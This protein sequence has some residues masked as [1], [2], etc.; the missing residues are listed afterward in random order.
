MPGTVAIPGPDS[1]WLLA[2]G[3]EVSARGDDLRPL[4]GRRGDVT[5]GIPASRLSVF[6]VLLPPTDPSLHDRMIFAQVEKRGLAGAPGSGTKIDHRLVARDP[7]GDVFAVTVVPDLPEEFVCPTAAGYASSAE[8][9]PAP[10]GGARLW[11]EGGRLVF[12]LFDGE[13]PLYVQI[14]SNATAVGEAAAREIGLILLGLAGDPALTAHQPQ[15]LE[16]C[17]ESSEA[18]REGFGR[19][20]RLPVEFGPAVSV[21]SRPAGRMALLPDGV[22]R[23]RRR[24]IAGRR[25]VVGLTAGLIIYSVLAVWL[26][27]SARGA[28]REIESLKEQVAIVEPDVEHVQSIEQRWTVLEPAFEKKWFPLVQLN[29]VTSALP[30][31]GVVVR[32][33]RTNGKNV[34]ITGQ[35][36][37]VQLANS[38]LEDLQA[39]DEFDAYSFSMPNPKVEKDNTA[40]FVISGEPKNASPD[41]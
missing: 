22:V 28:A 9:R 31:S 8:L 38:L 37:D 1:G 41:E 26:W 11:K 40:T 20:L 21:S 25:T 19:T 23:A 33:F 3:T 32:E 12:G 4:I 6:P 34:R 17:V 36:R 15:S 29:H 35:A 16:V 30:G 27:I 2:S 13:V 24:R 10:A 5:I 18:D 14:L 39:M 7:E